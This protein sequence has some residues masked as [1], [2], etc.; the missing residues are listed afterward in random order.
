MIF[1]GI[2]GGG[3]K[4]TFLLENS[5]GHELAR[6]ETGPS[7]WI[8]VGPDKA[9]ESISQGVINL[10][11]TP[12]VVCAGFAGA[13]RPEGAQFYQRC[14]SSL[15]PHTRVFVEIDAHIAY[16]GAI[17]PTPGV[18]LIAGTGSIAIAR[19]SDGTLIRA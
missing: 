11:F 7:N 14:L 9:R 2:D 8:S 18:L 4:T 6:F 17:G 3:S 16:M 5:E 13:G 1:L 10:P 15:L 19:K 12:D